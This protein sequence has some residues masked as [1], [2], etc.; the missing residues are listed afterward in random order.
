MILSG[1]RNTWGCCGRRK[2]A[3]VDGHSLLCKIT[4]VE[5]LEPGLALLTEELNAGKIIRLDERTRNRLVEL[6]RPDEAYGDLI[7][8]LLDIAAVQAKPQS[9][10]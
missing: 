3:V 6:A 8:R 10:A 4:K 1:R 2:E 5:S 9:N 7:N